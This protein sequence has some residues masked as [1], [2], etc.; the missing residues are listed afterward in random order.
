MIKNK[1]N[2]PKEI[3]LVAD[4]L[5]AS[6]YNAYLVG[7]CVRDILMGREPKDWD[8][9]TNAKPQ[10]IQKFFRTAFMKINSAQSPLK[11]GLI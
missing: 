7:G 4:K 11:H 10:E 6:G 1:I 2:I 5:M 8:I 9:T 3:I